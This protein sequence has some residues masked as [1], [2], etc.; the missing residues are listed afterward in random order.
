MCSPRGQLCSRQVSKGLLCSGCN[1]KA[2]E[3]GH[4]TFKALFCSKTD[5]DH[6]KLPREVI[7]ST[8]EE[9][10]GGWSMRIRPDLVNVDYPTESSVYRAHESNGGVNSLHPV[11]AQPG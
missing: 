9:Y 11:D 1:G 3:W 7:V 4:P 6:R 2:D 8:A 10:L 5:P